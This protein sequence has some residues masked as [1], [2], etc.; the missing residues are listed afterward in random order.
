MPSPD[1]ADFAWSSAAQERL[2]ELV[3]GSVHFAAAAD[4]L[5]G[6]ARLTRPGLLG[7][8]QAYLQQR[9]DDGIRSTEQLHAE[10]GDLDWRAKTI[11][12][13]VGAETGRPLS[14]PLL[15]DV[16]WAVIN[17][18]RHGRPGTACAKVFIKH[19]HPFDAFGCSSSVAAGCRGTRPARGSSSRPGRS[20]GCIPC[21]ARWPWP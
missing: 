6:G 14:L 9:W 16:G 13:V 21:A 11:T 7:P 18:V 2:D 1:L 19:R 12:I 5:I 3:P 10:L 8:H 17:Y 20:A 4:E 15:D